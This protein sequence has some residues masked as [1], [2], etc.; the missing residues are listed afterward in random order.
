MKMRTFAMLL[1]LLIVVSLWATACGGAAAPAQSGA[2]A[3][4]A[5]KADQP[6]AAAPASGAPVELRVAW[7]GSQDRHDRTIKA[8][9]LFQQK[10]PNIKVT[11]EF[12]GWD[13]YWTKMT[14]RRPATA[15][16]TSC[17]RTTPTS[18]SGTRAG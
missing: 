1:G 16:P 15:Y 17:S 10:N 11:Y 2:V 3:A 18:M 5:A 6:K 14:L 9:E 13:D 12:A 8:I 7:W 4:P